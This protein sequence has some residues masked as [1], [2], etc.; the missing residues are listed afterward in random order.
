MDNK[1]SIKGPMELH[2]EWGKK[3][4]RAFNILN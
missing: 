4:S 2:E 3:F 1:W